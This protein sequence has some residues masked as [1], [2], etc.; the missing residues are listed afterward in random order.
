[1][2]QVHTGSV[3]RITVGGRG[4][5]ATVIRSTLVYQVHPVGGVS[6]LVHTGS[7]DRITVPVVGESQ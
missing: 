6:D 5:S 1:M 3:D 4:E 2:Y 7:V